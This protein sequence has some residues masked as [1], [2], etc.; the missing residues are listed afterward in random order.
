VRLTIAIAH[1]ERETANRHSTHVDAPV[2]PRH[3]RRDSIFA[4]DRSRCDSPRSVHAIQAPTLPNPRTMRVLVTGGASGI[5]RACV[6]RL[7]S[8]GARVVF[9]G[10]DDELAP[11][12]YPARAVRSSRPTLG[13]K[14]PCVT[15]W[16]A[17][18]PTSAGWTASCA[19]PASPWMR[20]LANRAGRL[21][22]NPGRQ[23][24]GAVPLQRR[25][26][27][28]PPSG[29]LDDPALRQVRRGIGR[30][31]P[32]RVPRERRGRP[33][34]R[35]PDSGSPVPSGPLRRG[36]PAVGSAR[37]RDHYFY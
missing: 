22:G 19:R 25:V 37:L 32:G 20:P 8:D 18:S 1:V 10:R 6:E 30:C 16:I 15:R 28:G 7:A 11:R 4:A 9:A 13:T 21:A 26:P 36:R 17:R 5:G 27:P 2:T 31:R 35:G 24:H 23:P 14:R 34:E 29:D 12:S 33:R 3:L